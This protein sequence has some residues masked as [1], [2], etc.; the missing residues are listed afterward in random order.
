MVEPPS[1][2]LAQPAEPGYRIQVIKSWVD[3][4]A[5]LPIRARWFCESRCGSSE[6]RSGSRVDPPYGGF[7]MS[8]SE[9][10]AELVEAYKRTQYRAFAD[11]GEIVLRI[12]E[13]SRAAAQLVGAAGASGGAFIT[14]ENPL[15]VQ[16]PAAENAVRQGELRKD[17]LKL[18]A[19]VFEG[20]GQGD[21]PSW[22]AEASYAAIG[23][24]REQACELGRKYQ[25]NAIIWFDAGGT[26]E[27]I[28]LR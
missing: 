3:T 21:D 27:L 6:Q 2:P 28:V 8:G 23:I 20:A 10:P 17:L 7:F 24:S 22:P 19:S 5:N 9:I 15:S 11:S 26:P 25:Q 18:G 13:P 14:A 16:L 1:S 4:H 12:G